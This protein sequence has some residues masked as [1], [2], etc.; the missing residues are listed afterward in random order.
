MNVRPAR[1]V[2][3]NLVP[4]TKEPWPPDYVAVFAERQ[5]RL[6]AMRKDRRLA[7]GAMEYYRTRPVEFISDWCDTYDP[8]NAGGDLPMRLPFVLFRR[9]RELIEFFYAC[10][11]SEECG[12][13]EKCRDMG[14]TFAACAFSVW[15]FLFWPGS[16]VGWGSRKEDLV[17]KLGD[18]DSIFEKMRFIVRGLPP[19]FIPAGFDEATNM[20]FMRFVNP[21][22]MA[23]ITG[24]S[25]DNI[26]RGGRKLVYF[27][28]ES[29]HYERPEKIE[30]ALTDNTRVQIDMSSVNGLGNVFHTRR[31]N[32]A[33][34]VPGR[35]MEKA[36]TSVFVMDW[37]EHPAKSQA[38]YDARK[39][40]SKDDGLLHIFAQ[41]VD[42]NYSAAIVGVIIPGEWVAAAI[43]AHLALGFKDDGMYGAGLDVADEGGDTNALAVRKGLV[44]KSVEEWGDRDT[45]FTTRTAVD[46]VKRFAPIE[47]QYDSVGVGAGVKAEANRLKAEKQMPRNVSLVAWSAGASVLDP[48]GRVVPG[49]KNSPINEDFYEN[50]KAQAW[51]QLRRRFEV[52]YRARTESG[53]TFRR[54]DLISL[55]S[56]LP[57]LAKLRKELSQATAGPSK[58]LKLVV[59]KQPEGTK[60]PNLADAVVMA[61]WPVPA[62]EPA[63]AAVGT[64]QVAS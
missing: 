57:L 31:E 58:R 33:E 46:G 43:D 25:G 1:E 26:G 64:Y 34:Y 61:Y 30:A 49:D 7:V 19:E 35:A 39:K 55:P 5:R 36:R 38:W 13:V 54:G 44:L 51:W 62:H 59:N 17:D 4:R 12:L 20:S 28:D 11:T 48:R 37:R 45:G 22:T 23:T 53:Y 50:L 40:K 42:R 27:K 32:G 56:D 29:A 47:L 18:L 41:E 52:T 3:E 63:R 16:S 21:Q 14:A 9:Q 24:E 15:L 2:F 10:L 8:R 6:V 60:S